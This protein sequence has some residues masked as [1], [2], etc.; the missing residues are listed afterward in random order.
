MPFVIQEVLDGSLNKTYDLQKGDIITSINDKKINY[1][2]E[3]IPVLSENRNTTVEVELLRGSFTIQKTLNV[4]AEGKLGIM[5]GASM[6]DNIKLGLLEVSTIQYSFLESIGVGINNFVSFTVFYLEQ[7]VAIFNPSTGAYKGLGG[8]IAIGD[9]FP[10]SWDWGKFGL[11]TIS[12]IN[13]EYNCLII[14]YVRNF[15]FVAYSRI[16]RRSC[17][18]SDL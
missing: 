14:C 8:F 16:R 13:P 4:D 15:K 2:D 11:F 12:F 17:N 7:F 1:V 6:A 18:V 10:P 3:L 5:H 9:I